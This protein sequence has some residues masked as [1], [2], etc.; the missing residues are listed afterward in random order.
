MRLINPVPRF[1][2]F[3]VACNKRFQSSELTARDEPY[4]Y[5]CFGCSPDHDQVEAQKRRNASSNMLE[6]NQDERCSR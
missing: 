2:A 6:L 1:A 4:H 3:C 5:T